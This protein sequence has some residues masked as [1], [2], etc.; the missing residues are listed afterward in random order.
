M[1]GV[2]LMV[3]ITVVLS[4]VV[5]VLVSDLE[6]AGESAPE[7]A[8]MAEQDSVLVTVAEN[9]TAWSDL[10]VN[11]CT[12]VPTGDV[13]PGDQVTGCTGKVTIAH[14]QSGKLVFNHDF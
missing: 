11:G 2:I 5:F 9:G 8:F 14:N 7:L 12:G 13:E 10:T 3:A 1:I 6:G 4:A